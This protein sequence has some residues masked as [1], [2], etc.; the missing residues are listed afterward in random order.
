M[1]SHVHICTCG[2]QGGEHG[3][4]RWRLPGP[5][6]R[7]ERGGSL[8]G[9]RQP[10]QGRWRA[11]PRERRRAGGALARRQ[12]ERRPRTRQR[13]QREVVVGLRKKSS[14][15]VLDYVSVGIKMRQV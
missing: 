6:R 15:K 9:G 2:H 8:G 11:E 13:G 12:P 1:G 3:L 14:Q 5:G 7:R 4:W 10:V